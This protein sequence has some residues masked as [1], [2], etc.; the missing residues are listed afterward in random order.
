MAAR[1]RGKV[2]VALLGYG[3]GKSG[4]GLP[5]LLWQP[6]GKDGRAQ[7]GKSSMLFDQLDEMIYWLGEET[8]Q[9]DEMTDRL[10]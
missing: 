10:D 3:M 4:V 7:R 5:A 2:D 6:P 8:D 1:T 9:M